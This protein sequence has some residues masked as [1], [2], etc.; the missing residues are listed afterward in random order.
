MRTTR[1][2]STDSLR[3]DALVVLTLVGHLFAMFGYPLFATGRRK[4]SH[5]IAYP[6]QS[7]P[8]G[9]VTAE[10]CWMGDC[11]C[12]TI[13]EK[14]DWADA[15]GVKPPDHVYKLIESCKSRPAPRTTKSCCSDAKPCTPIQI[16]QPQDSSSITTVNC[17]DGTAT[18]NHQPISS[19]IEATL[20]CSE[21]KKPTVP[22]RQSGVRWVVG[23]VAKTCRGEGPGGLFQFE[24]VIV[25]ISSPTIAFEPVLFNRPV[26]V[27]IHDTTLTTPVPPPKRV[28]LP[29]DQARC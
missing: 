15:N 9:C 14:L 21:S 8:C 12:F 28:E 19:S 4:S 6:C 29:F 25:Q 27:F 18:C 17:C 10:E 11:C 3:R 13:E 23:V 2:R 16:V 24:P 1:W 7:R 20:S 26:S 22:L 5:G